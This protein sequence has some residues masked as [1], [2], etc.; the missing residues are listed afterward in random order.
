[1]ILASF[2]TSIIE[3]LFKGLANLF[4]SLFFESCHADTGFKQLGALGLKA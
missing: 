2:V 3:Q 1:L 4:G